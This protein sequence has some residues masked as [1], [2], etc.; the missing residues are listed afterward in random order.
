MSKDKE[1]TESGAT[2]VHRGMAQEDLSLEHGPSV[3]KRKLDQL[4]EDGALII[5]LGKV[6]PEHHQRKD[7]L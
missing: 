5:D 1:D 6:V 2:Y 7:Y 3:T 4:A